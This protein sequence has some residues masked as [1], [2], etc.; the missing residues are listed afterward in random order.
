MFV[1]GHD[2]RLRLGCAVARLVIHIAVQPKSESRFLTMRAPRWAGERRGGR[3][4]RA[5][6]RDFGSGS[7]VHGGG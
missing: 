6:E 4:T 5:T 1:E 2:G 3:R 7:T